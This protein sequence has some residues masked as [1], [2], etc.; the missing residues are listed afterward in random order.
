VSDGTLHSCVAGCRHEDNGSRESLLEGGRVSDTDNPRRKW[1]RAVSLSLDK[2]G[3]DEHFSR[4]GIASA[5]ILCRYRVLLRQHRAV[6][7]KLL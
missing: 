3:V 6:L 4:S 2:G 1:R 7:Y 5:S